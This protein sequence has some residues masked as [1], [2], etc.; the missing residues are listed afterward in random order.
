MNVSMKV[1]ALSLM[2]SQTSTHTIPRHVQTLTCDICG[3]IQVIYNRSRRSA[4]NSSMAVLYV[5]TPLVL[6]ARFYAQA[7]FK[8]L[9]HLYPKPN[10]N[11]SIYTVTWTGKWDKEEHCTYS[12]MPANHF[13]D[14]FFVVYNPLFHIRVSTTCLYTFLS[15]NCNHP[16]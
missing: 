12:L 8:R 7:C 14:L 1:D 10:A 9:P 4:E 6:V 15:E 2:L 5:R 3:Y 16:L 13:D 11:V